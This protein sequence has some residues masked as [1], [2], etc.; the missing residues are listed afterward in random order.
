MSCGHNWVKVCDNH[1]A[2]K[3]RPCSARYRRRFTR[4]AETGMQAQTRLGKSLWLLTLNAPGERAHGRW[5][6]PPHYVR[7]ARRVACDCHEGVV[8]A[9]WNPSA[10]ACWNRLRTALVKRYPDLDFLRTTETQSRGAIHYHLPIATVGRVDVLEVQALALAAGFGC[11]LDLAPLP[12]GADFSN[13][14]AYVSKLVAG[15]VTKSCDSRAD[16]PWRADV[17]D[18]ETG[19]IRRLHT[20]P[21]YR[22]HSQSRSWGITVGEV[23]RH[24]AAAARRR[25]ELLKA[26]HVP[27]AANPVATQGIER[28]STAGVGP[29]T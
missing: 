2:S 26:D 24:V 22:T 3:C 13:L 11:V 18:E 15:Y 4:V 8:L 25:A 20:H 19:E 14:A 21:T 10:S 29:P 28:V 5:T 23:R 1:R 7:G 12:R 9:D 6:P 27:H 17:V 16:V